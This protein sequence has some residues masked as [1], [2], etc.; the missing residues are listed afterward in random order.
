V[1]TGGVVAGFGG[2]HATGRP[3]RRRTAIPAA[4]R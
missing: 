4:F 1:D 2:A 3:P